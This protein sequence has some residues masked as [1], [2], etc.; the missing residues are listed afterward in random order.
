[1]NYEPSIEEQDLIYII[2]VKRIDS[3]NKSTPD[4]KLGNLS[5]T[6]HVMILSV[7]HRCTGLDH[8]CA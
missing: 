1:M 3:M 4:C 5:S 7:Q 6:Q 2:L 8:A